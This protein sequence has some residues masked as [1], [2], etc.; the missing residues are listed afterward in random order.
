M[1]P[2]QRS[3]LLAA[4]I[5][6]SARSYTSRSNGAAF[7]NNLDFLAPAPSNPTSIKHSPPRD[8]SNREYL[9][10]KVVE[11]EPSI[12][13]SLDFSVS[14][15]LKSTSNTSIHNQFDRRTSSALKQTVDSFDDSV[16]I[17]SGKDKRPPLDRPRRDEEI[18]SQW[19]RLITPD[20]NQGEKRLS[21]ALKSFDRTQYFLV[22][23]S[24]HPKLPI[25]KLV[26]K[27][28]LYEKN[29][30]SKMA[31]KANETVT[32]ELQLNW[33]TDPHDLRHKLSKFKGF[34]E[35]GYRIDVQING[36]KGKT[37]TQE[38]RGLVFELVKSEFEPFGKYVKQPEW[39]KAT[40]VTMALQGLNKSK[41]DK[42]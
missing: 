1:I 15:A 14:G 31:K 37:T 35:K 17:H 16:T 23:V 12:L 29:K 7:L 27:K 42:A 24:P 9:K 21:W 8:S 6:R 18:D 33:G 41:K 34:L 25:C 36:K 39:V 26:S 32:K 4:A 5:S 30:S 38:E 40:T 22:E 20:G 10:S 11:R 13:D 3:A 28:E 2:L 19:I